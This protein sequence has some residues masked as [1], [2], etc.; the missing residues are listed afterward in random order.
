MELCIQL[1]IV[2]IGSQL[3]GQI[4]EYSFPYI[5]KKWNV[6]KK[7]RKNDKANSEENDEAND[8]ENDKADLNEVKVE[9]NKQNASK[10]EIKTEGQELESFCQNENK[11]TVQGDITQEENKILMENNEKKIFE[12]KDHNKLPWESRGLF[13]E[14]LEMGKNNKMILAKI[15]K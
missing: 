5:I 9:S 8:I 4:Q 15:M 13:D 2:M 10:M 12:N 14:Y 7:K 6:Y 3:I 11:N 1:A